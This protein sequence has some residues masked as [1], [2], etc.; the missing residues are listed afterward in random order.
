M[1]R[2]LPFSHY[3]QE[4]GFRSRDP[5]CVQHF[6]REH[7]HGELN[8]WLSLRAGQRAADA[9]LRE[10]RRPRNPTFRRKWGE[11]QSCPFKGFPSPLLY[12]YITRGARGPRGLAGGWAGGRGPRER[13]GA[14]GDAAVP[15]A[16]PARPPGGARSS[17]R[18]ARVGRSHSVPGR[19]RGG[20][21]ARSSRGKP[22]GDARSHDG[23]AAGLAAPR[24]VRRRAVPRRA[25]PV[26]GMGV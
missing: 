15:P 21:G 16:R 26:F 13:G 23:A 14:G 10:A 6:Q 18:G 25:H 17:S 9:R 2:F 19:A 22:A 20:R 8:A 4:L 1:N 24:P 7:G 12:V 5:R 11:K 3:P